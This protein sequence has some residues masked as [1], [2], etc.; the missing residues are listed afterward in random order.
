VLRIV[1]RIVILVII[2]PLHLSPLST[3]YTIDG[4]LSAIDRSD[5]QRAIDSF[6]A[7]I[8]FVVCLTAFMRVPFP[9]AL[10]VGTDIIATR[11]IL[12]P[13]RPD[14]HRLE[15]LIKRFLHPT[16]LSELSRRFPSWI[17]LHTLKEDQRRPL[18]TW[19]A[20]RWAAKEAAKKAWDATLLSFGDLRVE[21]ETG[22]RVHIVCDMGAADDSAPH[23]KVTEQMAQLSISHD[24]DYTVATVLASPLHEDISAE[25]SLRKVAAETKVKG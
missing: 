15:R 21:T 17:A 8:T 10:R 11:R 19:L 22:G 18:A 25:L 3:D 12:C 2:S 13:A 4:I 20:G 23:N 14:Q 7:T 16:E 6:H 9:V 5:L 24:G 1:V